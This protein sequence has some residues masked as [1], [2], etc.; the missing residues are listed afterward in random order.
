MK[1]L[2][3]GAVILKVKKKS[4]EKIPITITTCTEKIPYGKLY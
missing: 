1:N 2:K 3:N 4:E